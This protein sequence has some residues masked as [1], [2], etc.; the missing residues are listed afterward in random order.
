MRLFVLLMLVVLAGCQ[1]STQERRA[2]RGVNYVSE[3]SHY[4][5][6]NVRLRSY[7]E[8]DL[9]EGVRAYVHADLAASPS[10]LQPYILDYWYED[11]ATLHFRNGA[12]LDTYV[13]AAASSGAVAGGVRLLSRRGEGKEELLEPVT[14]QDVQRLF[15][16]LRSNADL[17]RV[18]NNEE[19]VPAFATAGDRE[20]A[21]EVVGD[22]LKL[23]EAE[24]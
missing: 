20:A 21:I 18:V 22:Y 24:G 23:I 9:S 11:K 19:V 7:A 17:F 6:K 14:V 4:Y 3:P 10:A 2:A 12:G 8:T 16:L 1:G 15:N 13:A 5:F